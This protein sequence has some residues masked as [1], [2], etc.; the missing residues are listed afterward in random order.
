MKPQLRSKARQYALQALYQWE[1]A[2]NDS[3]DLAVQFEKNIENDVIDKV[4]FSRLL[5]GVIQHQAEL[6]EQFKPFLE[7]ELTELTP[8]ELTILR[9]A[10]FELQH[11]LDVPYKVVIN[12]ALE[13]T[14]EFGSVDEGFKFVNGVLD[15]VAA[16]LRSTEM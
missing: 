5:D 1:L 7:R 14:K 2:G 15:K 11:C 12:E 6:D 3:H 10:T 8:I 9:L 4:Y 13:L 16:K